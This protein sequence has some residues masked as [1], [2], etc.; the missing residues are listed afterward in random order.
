MAERF[1]IGDTGWIEVDRN[2]QSAA[3]Q[4]SGE[5]GVGVDEAIAELMVGDRD[6]AEYGLVETEAEAA[7]D[8]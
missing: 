7:A 3:F 5:E 8:D 2:V 1:E 4:V 6:P